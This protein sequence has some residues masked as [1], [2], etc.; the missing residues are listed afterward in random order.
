M[1]GSIIFNARLIISN[2]NIM[3]KNYT[4]GWISKI[5]PLTK[6]I[7]WYFLKIYKYIYLYIYIYIYYT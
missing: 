6:H 5:D 2:A 4:S 3:S 7:C 1:N